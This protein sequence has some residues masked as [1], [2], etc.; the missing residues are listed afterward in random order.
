MSSPLDSIKPNVRA[1]TAY[2]LNPLEAPVKIN[3]NENPFGMPPAIREEI[4]RRALATD[5]A[6]YPDFVPTRLLE[7]L[8]R[9]TGWPADGIMAGNGSNEMIQSVVQATIE[10]GRRVVLPEPT[11]SVY[12]QVVNVAGGE[13]AAVL[14]NPALQFDL[15]A[16][17]EA[18][19]VHDPVLTIICSPNNPTGCTIAREDLI[20]LL[21]ATPGLVIVDQ[22]YLE[23]GGEDFVPLLRDHANLVILRTFSKAMAMGGL[24]VG[25][26]LA[27][28][29]LITE[30]NKAKMPYS[31]NIFSM[32]AAEVTLER[33]HELT[34][35]VEAMAR[36]RERLFAELSLIPGLRPVPSAGNFLITETSIPP[37]QL[38]R[39]LHEHGFLIRDISKSP[40]LSNYVRIS[41]GTP[42]ENTHLLAALRTIFDNQ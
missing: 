10:K 27:A 5:W 3:Q 38:F 24:R 14:L 13:V 22:A 28:P 11:F 29:Q 42:D 17:H 37:A 16:I 12:R 18:I 32:I 19:R 6:R 2:T 21:R 23:I 7:K 20:S 25:Y 36:E 31:L 40:L 15:P 8:A 1:I 9:Y 35:L 26:C 41:V 34:P 30:F 33:Q 4:I 39:Q